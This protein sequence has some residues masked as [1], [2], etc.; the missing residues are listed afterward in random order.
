[1]ARLAR[2]VVPGM[3]H[4][5]TQ[6]GNRRQK[7]FFRPGDYKLYLDIFGEVAPEYGLEL[8]C[9]CLMPNHVHLIVVPGDD[10]SLARGIGEV[11]RRYTRAVHARKNWRGYLW[12]GRFASY[13]M[14]DAH[15]LNAT[16]YVLRNPV[17]ARLVKSPAAWRWSS[18][19]V[20]LGRER[21]RVVVKAPLNKMIRNWPLFLGEAEV[22]ADRTAIEA[23]LRTGRPRG[24]DAFV[25]ALE[26]KLGRQL[27]PL[28]RG[29]KP[30]KSS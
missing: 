23:A 2:V 11:H 25:K 26:R 24:T 9:Y 10:E 1:M 7:T 16:R 4:H 3:P 15:L 6:R 18:A 20:H 19:K 5:I 30:R 8:W 17:A 13:V 22:P 27:R 21:S 28:K 14:D 12:Q 29:P